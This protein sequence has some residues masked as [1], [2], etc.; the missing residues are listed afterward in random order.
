M[1]GLY[2]CP[3]KG[4]CR[5]WS[6]KGDPLL[7]GNVKLRVHYRDPYFNFLVEVSQFWFE[8]SR[9][10]DLSRLFAEARV[11][12]SVKYGA[13]EKMRVERDIHCPED[14]YE[15]IGYGHRNYQRLND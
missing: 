12:I 4:C 14:D 13:E 8:G 15:P 10:F 5:D 9:M 6:L 3:V 7:N 11:S 1:C 2:F